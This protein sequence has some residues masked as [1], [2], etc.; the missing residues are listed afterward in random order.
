MIFNW[1]VWK[2]EKPISASKPNKLTTSAQR[3]QKHGE[4]SGIPKACFFNCKENKFS[5]YNEIE[6]LDKLTSDWWH[7]NSAKTNQFHLIR[8]DLKYF[9]KKRV[10]L[11]VNNRFVEMFVVE[12]ELQFRISIPVTHCRCRRCRCCLFRTKIVSKHVFQQLKM[13]QFHFIRMKAHIL[14]IPNETKRP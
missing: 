7:L 5:Y 4:K 8:N 10:V 11:K 3:H 6:K 9:P 13:G 12:F 2:P 14:S 1:W